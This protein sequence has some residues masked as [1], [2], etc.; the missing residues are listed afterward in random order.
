MPI[1]AH[2]RVVRRGPCWLV[3][4]TPPGRIVWRAYRAADVSPDEAAAKAGARAGVS[5]VAWQLS[6]VEERVCP[7]LTVCA[8]KMM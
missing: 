4:V 1:P 8:C 7:S 6:L 3:R 2:V 5:A